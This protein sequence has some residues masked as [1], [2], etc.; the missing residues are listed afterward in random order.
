MLI[1]AHQP[2]HLSN[3]G[4]FHKMVLADTFILITNVQ[5]EKQEGWQRRHKIP[6]DMKDIWLTVPV[7]GS[8]NTLLKDVR[9]NSDLR[10]QK[11]ITK[12]LSLRY[13]K[14][15]WP[16]IRDA[17]CAL[18]CKRWL[19]LVDLNIALI[20][21]IKKV[22]EIHTPLVVDEEVTG[23]KFELLVNICK[24][25][26]SSDYLSGKGAEHY[27]DEGYIASM[28]EYA[29]RHHVIDKPLTRD[30]PYTSVHY[31]LTKGPEYV[32]EIIHPNYV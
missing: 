16:E 18:Y 4:F 5:F 7:D 24:K 23:R 31:I 26:Q 30:F 21:Y 20:H 11:K 1:A 12:T 32:K 25:Y 28:K 8:Q 9:I 17:L 29:I 22:L 14:T 6:G 27:M 10:W 3:L 2:N 15:P 19:R 13:K